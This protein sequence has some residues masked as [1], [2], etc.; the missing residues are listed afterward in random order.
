MNKNLQNVGVD[1]ALLKKTYLDSGVLI[2]A[3]QG[4]QVNSIQANNILNDENREFVYSLFVKLE[5]L[6]KAI[7]NQQ[8]KEK[9]FYETFFSSVTHW[10]TDL[11]QI[12]EDGYEIACTY[13][14]RCNRCTSCCRCLVAK[15]IRI[16]Y[17]RKD[18]QTYTQS[19]SN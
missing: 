18:N 14:E 9:D 10:A 7:Y 6:P 11:E 13:G 19:Y 3:F 12:T 8:Q 5:I 15:S 2:T 4:V 1:I 17:Y 16:S